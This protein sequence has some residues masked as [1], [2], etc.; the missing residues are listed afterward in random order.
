MFQLST[1]YKYDMVGKLMELTNAEFVHLEVFSNVSRL[2]VLRKR[3]NG[4]KQ[5]LRK[6]IFR[7]FRELGQVSRT[8]ALNV[9]CTHVLRFGCSCLSW[10]TGSRSL[11]AAPTAPTGPRGAET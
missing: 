1:E 4:I 5:L 3:Y 8:R 11:D 10:T 7:E 9:V 2:E 6:V